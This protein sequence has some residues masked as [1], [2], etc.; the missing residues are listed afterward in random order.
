[1]REKYLITVES[2]GKKAEV[3][4]LLDFVDL[5]ALVKFMRALQDL[6]FLE[7]GLL[8]KAVELSE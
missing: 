2:K 6:G 5:E 4:M 3:E 1:M 7:P 8:M